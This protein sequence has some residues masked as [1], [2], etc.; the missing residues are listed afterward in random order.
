MGIDYDSDTDEKVKTKKGWN[1][2]SSLLVFYLFW[3]SS[4]NSAFL[5]LSIV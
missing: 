2:F 4:Q 3:H 1:V 5:W